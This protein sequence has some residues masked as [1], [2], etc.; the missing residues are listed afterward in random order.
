M[1]IT[2]KPHGNWSC[3]RLVLQAGLRT[4]GQ[5]LSRAK[6]RHAGH[7]RRHQH[8]CRPE[9]HH[10]HSGPKQLTADLFGNHIKSHPKLAEDLCPEDLHCWNWH[11]VNGSVT[12][13]TLENTNG[14]LAAILHHGRQLGRDEAEPD[15]DPRY[16]TT[17]FAVN[18][19]FVAKTNDPWDEVTRLNDINRHVDAGSSHESL[20]ILYPLSSQGFDTTSSR[21]YIVNHVRVAFGKGELPY[22]LKICDFEKMSPGCQ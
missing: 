12:Q 3:A 9:R 16:S 22:V 18:C 14:G 6:C 13:K 5:A 4:R 21:K 15:Q 7:S 20:R 1:D 11:R 10:Q 8:L 19:A 17:F 2:E